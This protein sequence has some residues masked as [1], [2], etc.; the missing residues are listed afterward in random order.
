MK[1]TQF[2]EGIDENL[3]E[4]TGWHIGDGSM[5]YYL[6]KRWIRGIYQLRGHI[7]DDRS[8]YEERIKPIFKKIYGIDISLREMHSTR[9][10]GFQ[11]WSKD[12]VKFKQKLGLPIG[13]KRDI[14]I[15]SAFLKSIQIKMAVVRG[16]F[17]TDGCIYLENKNHKLYPKVTITTISKVLAEQVSSI[18]NELKIKNSINSYKNKGTLTV[19]YQ[20]VIRGPEMVGNFFRD[21]GPQNKKHLIKYRRFLDS[22]KAL[23]TITC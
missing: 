11:V 6:D 5:N 4:E 13:P 7:Y 16:I 3:A 19:A 18:L 21:I 22:S 2:P 12:L 10:F 17:D 1:V 9:V 8:H 14:K 23:K 15:P 20:L